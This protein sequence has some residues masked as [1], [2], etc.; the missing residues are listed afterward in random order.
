MQEIVE[1]IANREEL[2]TRLLKN[3]SESA[4]RFSGLERAAE[5]VLAND[6]EAN[7][8]KMLNTSMKILRDQMDINKDLLALM[9][10]FVSSDDYVANQARL[11]IK[12][13]AD[14]REVLSQMLKMKMRGEF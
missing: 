7:T 8:R 3:F 4:R 9:I 12:L 2:L 11:A 14:G 1:R 5:T 10:M 6:S 13:G